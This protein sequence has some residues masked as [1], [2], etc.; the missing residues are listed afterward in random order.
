MSLEFPSGFLA[1]DSPFYINRPPIEE[2]TYQEISKPGCLIRIKAPRKTG[3]SSLLQRV[4]THAETQGYHSVYLN[5]QQIDQEYLCHKDK[6]LRWF[7]ANVSRQLGLQSKLDDYW[8][9][10][11]GSKVSCTVYLQGY[12]LEQLEH[13]LVLAL[14]EVQEIFEYRAITQEF[15]PLLRS[16]HEEAKQVEVLRQLRLVVAHCTEIYVPLDFNQS[17]FNVG[18][19]IRLPE[20]TLEQVEELA[21]RYGLNWQN[22]PEAKQLMDMVGG[23]PYL[24]NLAL[25]HLCTQNL[26][27]E[28]LLQ[29][30]PTLAG[31][32]SEHLR[33]HLGE[34][35]KHLGLA[36]ALNQVV[37]STE[38]VSLEPN[39]AYQL[40][41]MGLI[42][43]VGNEAFPSCELYR[44]YFGSQMFRG[45]GLS[46]RLAQLERDNQKLE[47]LCFVDELTQLANRTCFNDY[48]QTEWEQLASKKV[49][50]S[51]IFGNLDYFKTYNET[52]G[53]QEGDRCLQKIGQTIGQCALRPS[54]L[55][56]RYGG[57][58]FALI[59]PYTDAQGVAKVAQRV[60]DR[61]R[62]LKIPHGKNIIGLPAPI[63]TISVGAATMIPNVEASPTM[64]INA[65]QDALYQSKQQGRDCFTVTQI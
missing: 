18:L 47:R 41:S 16:W 25:Y 5:F 1:I 22:Y 6:F 20:F 45:E 46:A 9:E 23:H 36:I 44:L 12:I 11:I 55:A 54:D 4:I 14:D 52:Y 48:L 31:I 24:I 58:E 51:L 65:A 32:Y 42:K 57:E 56:I 39:F 29:A 13:P 38:S 64:L 37:T 2:L 40:E 3:K 26:S 34:L 62:A 43:L 30:A 19:P 33:R 17:P 28:S 7:C 50:L 15:L 59:L 8:D 27:L 60:R 61:V 53:H 49:P 35:Q 21:Q 63:V 10:D